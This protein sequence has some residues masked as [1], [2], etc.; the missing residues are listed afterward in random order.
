MTS[1]RDIEAA[2]RGVMDGDV[3]SSIRRRAEYSSDASNYRIDPR[4]VIF[5]RDADDMAAALTVARD[6]SLPITMRGGGTSVAGNAIGD[7]LVIDTSRYMNKVLHV[8]V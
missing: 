8:D 6:N 3:D 5:P 1:V 7:G 4:L 2:L